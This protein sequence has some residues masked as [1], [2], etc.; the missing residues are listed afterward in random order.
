MK[1]GVAP[2]ALTTFKECCS[3]SMYHE[4]EDTPRLTRGGIQQNREFGA[5]KP[6]PTASPRDDTL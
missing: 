6:T 3:G 2:C 5:T 4:T 1:S